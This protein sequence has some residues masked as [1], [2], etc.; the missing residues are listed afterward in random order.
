VVQPRTISHCYDYKSGNSTT[1]TRIGNQTY[2][3]GNSIN[4]TNWNNTTTRAGNAL[5]QN[6]S[7]TDG[8]R[9]NSTAIYSGQQ[10]TTTKEAGR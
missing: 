6:G 4:G 1:T 9:W 8:R 7:A 10:A 5:Y 2:T 3:Y